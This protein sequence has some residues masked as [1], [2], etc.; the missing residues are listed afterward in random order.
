MKKILLGML[1]VAL[2][3]VFMACG[4]SIEED[5]S[6]DAVKTEEQ[7]RIDENNATI[8]PKL[9]EL[10]AVIVEIEKVVADHGLGEQYQSAM[11]QIRAELD[12]VTQNHQTIIDMGGYLKGTTEFEAAV[13]GAIE[14]DKAIL[15]LILEDLETGETGEADT[16]LVDKFNALI[17]L[18]NQVTLKAQETGWDKDEDM[19]SELGVVYGF[20]DEVKAKLE[21]SETIDEGYKTEKIAIINALLPVFEAYL[22][23]VSVPYIE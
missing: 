1:L 21:S 4:D 20:M 2:S 10:E 14:K 3:I 22:Q 11:D 7:V 5:R 18:V 13:V 6:P 23:K 12:E 15:N 8:L 9:D 16:A 19:L 17:D